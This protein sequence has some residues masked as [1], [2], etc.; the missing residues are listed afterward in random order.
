M[1]ILP[2]SPSRPLQTGQ[3]GSDVNDV[4]ATTLIVESDYTCASYSY[5]LR[6]FIAVLPAYI[7][8]A[9]CIRRYLDSK[10]AHHL[11]NAGKY[12]TAFVKVI[13]VAV[14][15]S[16]R[17]NTSLA[18]YMMGHVVSSIYTLYWDLINDWGLLR[19][20][21]DNYLVRSPLSL[22]TKYVNH[23]KHCKHGSFMQGC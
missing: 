11:Y 12:S 16:V 18:F 10:R 7:R 9:Q 20:H 5:G 21:S 6:Y 23:S 13:T 22:N 1:R 14:H 3:P 19:T 15:E 8:F 4:N 2:Y 17:S